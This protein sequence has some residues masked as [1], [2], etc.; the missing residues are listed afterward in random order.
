MTLQFRPAISGDASPIA[1]LY[2]E[3]RTTFLS[4]A[5]SAHTEDEVRGWIA[6]ILIP[7]GGVT[8]VEEDGVLLGMMALSQEDGVGWLDQLYLR[9]SAT[10]RGIGTQFVNQT[11]A[12]LGPPIHLYT[13]QENTGARRFYERH[14]F[15]AIAFSDGADNE[16]KCP[17]VLYEWNPSP[18]Y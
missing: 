15:V 18:S 4:Y 9:P 6:R 10:G 12:T 7:A 16:E 5:P 14:G 1:D 13:F 2:W 11:K 3:S 8:V 17:D